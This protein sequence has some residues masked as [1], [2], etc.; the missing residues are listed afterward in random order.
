MGCTD[1]E[2]FFMCCELP[3]HIKLEAEEEKLFL[4]SELESSTSFRLEL[5]AEIA[6][7]A[8]GGKFTFFLVKILILKS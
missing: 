4:N 5:L 3:L 6:T 8:D 7:F 2:L 1:I